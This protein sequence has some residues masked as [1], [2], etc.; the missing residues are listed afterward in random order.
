MASASELVT[1]AKKE[2][3]FGLLD[4]KIPLPFLLVFLSLVLLLCLYYE[5]FRYPNARTSPFYLNRQPSLLFADE[6]S[7][8][9]KRASSEAEDQK[10]EQIFPPL[11]DT[12]LKEENFRNLSRLELFDERE[13]RN[14][15]ISI[16]QIYEQRRRYLQQQCA[17]NSE[18]ATDSMNGAT[19]LPDRFAYFPRQSLL[20]CAIAKCANTAW[21]ALLDGLERDQVPKMPTGAPGLCK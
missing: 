3:Y 10:C 5:G 14:W 8:E 15:N 20:Y 12:Q 2:N 11:K 6:L 19:V 1:P 4:V 17:L 21:T 13:R 9:N 7:I 18:F 16:D